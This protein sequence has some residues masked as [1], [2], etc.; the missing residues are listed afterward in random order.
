MLG[1]KLIDWA[2]DRRGPAYRSG[3]L[4]TR[5]LSEKQIGKELICHR[6]TLV[7]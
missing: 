7:G 2:V 3:F 5:G 6:L 4:D 1:I